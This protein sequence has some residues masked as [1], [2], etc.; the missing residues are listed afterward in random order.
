MSSIL[1]SGYAVA[2]DDWVT[3]CGSLTHLGMSQLP[4]RHFRSMDGTI[5]QLGRA[6]LA[7]KPIETETEGAYR[8][9]AAPSTCAR[10]PRGTGSSSCSQGSFAAASAVDCATRP[11]ASRKKR[12][13][14]RVL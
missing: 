6:S 8:Q 13:K 9:A 11:C 5:Y 1:S 4:A 12:A 3:E 7:F 2:H 14:E 10:S